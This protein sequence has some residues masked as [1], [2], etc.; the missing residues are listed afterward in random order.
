MRDVSQMC[1]PEVGNMDFHE[2]VSVSVTMC[3]CDLTTFCH[4]QK[5][6]KLSIPFFLFW[7]VSRLAFINIQLLS[8]QVYLALPDFQN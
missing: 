2:Q 1:V 7:S 3:L 4:W 5:E 8:K 6:M